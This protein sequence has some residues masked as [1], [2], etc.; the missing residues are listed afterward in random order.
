MRLIQN[1]R[2]LMLRRAA[3]LRRQERSEFKQKLVKQLIP[4]ILIYK[5][6]RARRADT[7][8]VRR[9]IQRRLRE[10]AATKFPRE[11]QKFLEEYGLLVNGSSRAKPRS[12]R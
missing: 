10:L 5:R 8:V 7:L 4:L 9:K 12:R 2:G 11:L 3:R 1:I 6:D